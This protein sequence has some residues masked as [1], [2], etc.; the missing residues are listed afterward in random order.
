MSNDDKPQEISIERDHPQTRKGESDARGSA[1]WN[2]DVIDPEEVPER[3][4]AGGD[5]AGRRIRA[6]AAPPTN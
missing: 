5:A 6:N 2:E 4:Q 3:M 1:Q